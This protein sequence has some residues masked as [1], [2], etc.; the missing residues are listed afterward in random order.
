MML[1]TGGIDFASH[2]KR[3]SHWEGETTYTEEGGQ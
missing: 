3:V 2:D 1:E